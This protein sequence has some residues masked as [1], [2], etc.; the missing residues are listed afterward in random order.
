[1]S[2]LFEV[3]RS[4]RTREEEQLRADE[5][6]A[7]K[8]NINY[9]FEKITEKLGRELR[10][11]RER[12]SLMKEEIN[13]KKKEF[14]IIYSYLIDREFFLT[15]CRIYGTYTKRNQPKDISVEKK[16]LNRELTLSKVKID[17]LKKAIL[18]FKSDIFECEEKQRR[19]GKDLRRLKRNAHI[20]INI[21]ESSSDSSISETEDEKAQRLEFEEF[22]KLKSKE[23]EDLESKC[24]NNKSII[25][26]LQNE[27]KNAKKV[28]QNPALK[29]Q[30]YESLKDY[31][32]EIEEQDSS[33]SIPNSTR[34][35]GL[36]RRR[37]YSNKA[38]SRIKTKQTDSIKILAPQ[39]TS[40]K[41]Y[42]RK[43][44]LDMVR[45]HSAPRTLKSANCLQRSKP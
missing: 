23:L 20:P 19:L 24:E 28:L 43:P 4:S 21:G 2:K 22:K 32:N 12:N 7:L 27:L 36:F 5:L 30:I 18:I 14:S 16:E 17:A 44:T 15:E 3:L 1:M 8:K 42:P 9:S 35:N 33:S 13:T 39:S 29:T 34:N 25:L 11:R 26:S 40:F 10:E 6:E 38:N 31:I 37:V 45:G 41:F